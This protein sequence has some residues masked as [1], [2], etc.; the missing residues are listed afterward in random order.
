[1]EES[2]SGMTVK[3]LY[4]PQM[5]LRSLSHNALFTAFWTLGQRHTAAQ[6]IKQ[7]TDLC[8]YDVDYNTKLD[9]NLSF[10]KPR[11]VTLSFFNTIIEDA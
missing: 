8:R 6:P 7:K 9:F 3:S 5:Q 10:S 11:F 2:K 1:M 4:V